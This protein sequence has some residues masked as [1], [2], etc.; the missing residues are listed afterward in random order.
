MGSHA[1]SLEASKGV[2]NGI[3]LGC[4]LLLPVGT[5][6]CVATLKG[7]RPGGTAP[8]TM[9]SATPLMTSHNTEGREAWQHCTANHEL[10][11]H[12]DDVTRH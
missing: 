11:H 6:N 10:C 5:V 7:V 2:T 1:C 3:P 4:S 8:L 12:T 9:D